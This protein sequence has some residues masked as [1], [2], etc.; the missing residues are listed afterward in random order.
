MLSRKEK[1]ELVANMLQ[2]HE[3]LLPY[4]F[5][6]KKMHADTRKKLLSIADFVIENFLAFS[7]HVIIKDILLHGSIC[8]YTYSDSSDIDIFI[9]VDNIFPNQKLTEV[10]LNF[11]NISLANQKNKPSFYGHPVDYGILHISN[12]RCQGRNIYSLL[13]D[14]WNDEPVR[15]EYPFTAE[16]LFREYCQYSAKLHEYVASL[17]KIDNAFLT[18]ES[19]IKLSDYLQM[20][21]DKAFEAKNNSPEREYSLD[22]NLYRLLKRF[23]TYAHFKN[24]IQDS[25]K[26]L[27]RKKDE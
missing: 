11:M 17:E 7:P 14:K 19:C 4:L 8:S 6:E 20:L 2:N 24:Y 9:V 15:L 3:V 5:D 25:Y 21:R 13:Y 10:I 12:K 18:K 23:N 22:Y 26:N 16:E 1:L 27:I